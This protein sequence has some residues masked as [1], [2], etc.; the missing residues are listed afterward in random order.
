MS[1]QAIAAGAAGLSFLG[2][3]MANAKNVELAR[4]QMR[5][6][7]RMSNTARQREVADLKAAGLNPMMALGSG[8]STPIGASGRVEDAVGPAVNSG[9]AAKRL[10]ADLDL[11]KVQ[12]S[13][14]M[15]EERLAAAH[16]ARLNQMWPLERDKMEAET[17]EIQGR[18]AQLPQHTKL[19][20]AEAT[21]LLAHGRESEARK[22]L[23]DVQRQLEELGVPRAEAE[24]NFWKSAVGKMQPYVSSARDVVGIG[25]S[26]ATPLSIRAGAKAMSRGTVTERYDARGTHKGTTYTR[27]E[28]KK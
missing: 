15:S 18:T 16:A 3:T 6:Q 5:F 19:L 1:A 27:K 17:A 25:T 8:A 4:E 22:M 14:L 20:I 24:A 2:Q 11:M 9:M 23:V 26:L 12:T 10:S 7:E 21:N 13:K 28:D